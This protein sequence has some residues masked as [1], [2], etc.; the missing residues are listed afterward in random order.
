MEKSAGR[1][2]SLREK[3]K[4]VLQQGAKLKVMLNNWSSLV[5]FSRNTIAGFAVCLKRNGPTAKE[6]CF[7]KFRAVQGC[8]TIGKNFFG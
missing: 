6:G 5:T 4:Q 7:Q 2:T 3:A 1:P 8:R